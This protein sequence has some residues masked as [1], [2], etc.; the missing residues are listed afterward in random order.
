MLTST[1]KRLLIDPN[2]PYLTIKDQCEA[3]GLNRSTYYYKPIPESEENIH[4]MK[5]I[6]ELH[7]KLPEY[8]YRKIHIELRRLGYAVND[9]RVERLWK[10]LGFESILPR[11]NLS[12]P[13]ILHQVFPYLLNGMWIYRPNQV[14]SAD[15]TFLPLKGSFVYL[16]MVIDWYSRYIVSW[17]ISNSMSVHFCLETLDTA[18]ETAIPDYFN[19]D[20]GSQFTSHDFVGRL[21]ERSIKISMDSKGRAIDNVYMERGW[22][23]LKY[24][25]IYPNPPDSVPDLIQ[26]VADYVL[27]YNTKRPHQSLLYA[28]PEEI[29]KGLQPLYS[30]GEYTGFK[31]KCVKRR[32]LRC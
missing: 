6:E 14:F 11:K 31:V 29:Y 20:Q 10:L 17:K 4:L 2:H 28:T 1:E 8:G 25:K 18:L 9:K 13:N 16:T 24:E 22:W 23:S 19:T 26:D 32:G 12:Q 21:L 3:L 7:Y 15:I 30:Q 27:H 5:L